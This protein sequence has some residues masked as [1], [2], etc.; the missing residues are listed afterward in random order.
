MITFKESY[1]I[2]VKEGNLY[3][4]LSLTNLTTKMIEIDKGIRPF[5]LYSESEH[6]SPNLP[7]IYEGE[8]EK[9]LITFH[10]YGDK[11]EFI[12][13]LSIDYELKDGIHEYEVIY[14]E[15]F[16]DLTDI[17]QSDP[18]YFRCITF[19]WFKF[20][21]SGEGYLVGDVNYT[22]DNE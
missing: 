9:K 7:F 19:T 2:F 15:N 18:K 4:S 10:K 16:F 12:Y 13:N 6:L 1:K 3:L 5:S 17:E 22:V 11:Y 8:D 20:P 21:H 14:S